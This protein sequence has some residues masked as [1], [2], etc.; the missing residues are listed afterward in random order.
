MVTPLLVPSGPNELTPSSGLPVPK[1]Y[2]QGVLAYSV[3]PFA[4]PNSKPMRVSV[5]TNGANSCTAQVSVVL[6]T[7]GSAVYKVYPSIDGQQVLAVTTVLATINSTSQVVA[8]TC[9]TPFFI[10]D[11]DTAH[12]SS[13]NIHRIEGS[14]L[15]TG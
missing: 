3:E 13:G 2:G 11:L 9:T 5:A 4:D 7:F 12:G 14:G 15:R 8:F 10:I 1:Q 6:G